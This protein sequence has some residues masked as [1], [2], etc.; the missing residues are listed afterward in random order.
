MKFVTREI[1]YTQD[2]ILQTEGGY[3]VGGDLCMRLEVLGLHFGNITYQ[4]FPAES[5]DSFFFHTGLF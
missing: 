3:F 2:L 1:Y 5:S 4:I